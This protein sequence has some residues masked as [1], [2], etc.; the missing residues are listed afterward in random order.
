MIDA[1]HPEKAF[2]YRKYLIDGVVKYHT[3]LPGVGDPG[4]MLYYVVKNGV[5]QSVYSFGPRSAIYAAI[6]PATADCTVKTVGYFFRFNITKEKAEKLIAE[7]N[8][9]RTAIAQG[10]ILYNGLVNDTC[11]ST[12]LENLKPYIPNLPEGRGNVGMGNVGALKRFEILKLITPY[13][14][15]EDF[16]K[17][18]TPYKIYPTDKI[19]YRK[20]DPKTLVRPY[21]IKANDKDYI[22]W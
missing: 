19:L 6:G 5:I 3:P 12:G 10:K 9:Q 7:T 2:G 21:T 20:E 14:L 22:K 1:A 4:H 15:F 8:R 11:A 13:W 18:G 17:A 16:K